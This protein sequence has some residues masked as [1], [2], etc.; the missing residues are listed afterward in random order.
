MQIR[1]DLM[2]VILAGHETTASEMAW[3]LQ[4]LAHNPPVAARLA[5]SIAAGD[6]SYLRATVYEVL[7]PG[8]CSSLRSPAY[9]T[10]RTSSAGAPTCHPSSLSGASI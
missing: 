6:G 9:A 5:D 1:E 7:R 10:A 2:S 8:P 4:L 3:A